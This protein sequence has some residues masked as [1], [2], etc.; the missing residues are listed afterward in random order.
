MYKNDARPKAKFIMWLQLQDKLLTTDRLAKWGIALDLECVMFH[1]QP[2]SRN[3]LF[4]DCDFT[5][6][7]WNRI[8]LWLQKQER[9]TI[10]WDQ[11]VAW[12]I[13]NVKGRTQQAHI[14]KSVY[15]ECVYAIWMERNQRIFEKKSRN[16][17]IIA[18]EIAYLSNVRASHGVQNLLHSMLF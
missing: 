1:T 4:M 8:L 9:P 14:F 5:R 17:E 6:A 13:Q 16:W 15:A 18:R 11:H 2:E 12:I 7:V 3:H 10:G